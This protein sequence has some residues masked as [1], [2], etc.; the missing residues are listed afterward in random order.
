MLVSSS[1][2]EMQEFPILFL[3]H[4]G[5]FENFHNEKNV[6]FHL[7]HSKSMMVKGTP[8]IRDREGRAQV[9]T[10]GGREKVATT[11][12]SCSWVRFRFS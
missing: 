6:I 5:M 3:Q 7:S 10:L 8:A 2:E 1:T 9:Q 12:S 11:T 4:S